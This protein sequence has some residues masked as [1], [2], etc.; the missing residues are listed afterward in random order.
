MPAFSPTGGA[1]CARACVCVHE[2]CLWQGETRTP[3]ALHGVTPSARP[4]TA[5]HTAC[6]V[7]HTA[8]RLNDSVPR[9][10]ALSMPVVRDVLRGKIARINIWCGSRV[11][12]AEPRHDY[13]YPDAL[14]PPSPPPPCEQL[15]KGRA[16]M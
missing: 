9:A 7:S 1:P 2:F 12:R 5:T 16:A 10:A 13:H 3:A 8:M 11:V 4:I 6:T 15:R 14:G